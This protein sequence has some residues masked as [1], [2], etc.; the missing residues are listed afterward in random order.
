MRSAIR[1]RFPWTAR[2]H[3]EVDEVTMISSFGAEKKK[4][5]RDMKLDKLKT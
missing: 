5:A 2:K 4:R 3:T 1:S